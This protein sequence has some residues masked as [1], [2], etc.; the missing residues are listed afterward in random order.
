MNYCLKL[1]NPP[2]KL[3]KML[4]KLYQRKYKNYSFDIV[5]SKYHYSVDLTSDEVNQIAS[6]IPSICNNISWNCITDAGPPKPTHIDR[7]RKAALQIPII[8]DPSIHKVFV[9]KEENMFDQLTPQERGTGFIQKL[10]IVWKNQRYKDM[11]MFHK[12]EDQYFDVM[13]V[14]PYIPYITATDIPHGG[15]HNKG[16]KTSNSPRYFFSC[17]LPDRIDFSETV[18]RFKSWH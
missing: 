8:A 10:D 6:C 4:K 9:L 13:T 15:I 1:N 5:M 16:M 14:E 2:K 11:P 3:I 18:E 7:G 12:Y 17:S